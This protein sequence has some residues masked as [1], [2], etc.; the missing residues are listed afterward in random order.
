MLVYMNDFGNLVQILELN[1]SNFLGYCLFY[2]SHFL[3]VYPDVS[4]E[5]T[6]CDCVSV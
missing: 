4:L 6:Q 3:A 1:N 2:L 5:W